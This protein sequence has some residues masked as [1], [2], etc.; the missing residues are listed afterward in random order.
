MTTDTAVMVS[1]EILELKKKL[2]EMKFIDDPDI[3]TD[4]TT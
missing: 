2:S 1:S 3:A 4:A